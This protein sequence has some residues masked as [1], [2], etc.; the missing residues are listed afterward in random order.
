MYR[1]LLAAAAVIMLLA[2]AC[3]G[4]AD[5][6][7]AEPT[8]SPEV[9]GGC[10]P[11]RP[12]AAGETR[13]TMTSGAAERQYL[14]DVPPSYDGAAS[15][16]VVIAL[17]GLGSSAEQLRDMT[18]LDSA[19][20][21]RGMIVVFPQGAEIPAGWNIENFP[22]EPDDSTFI[23]DLIDALDE[24][25]C[26]DES[27]IYLSGYSNGGGMALRFACD[28]GGRVAGV[29]AVAATFPICQ[30]DAPLIAFHGNADLVVPYEGG[31]APGVTATLAPV[32]RAAS[33]WARLLGCDGL[34]RISRFAPDV[35]LATYANCPTASD[36]T[37]LYTVLGG[38]HTWP[39][40]VIDL[41][42]SLAG[43][44]TRSISA[45]EMMLDFFEAHGGQP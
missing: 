16:A 45:T 42:P 24:T 27:R 44:T 38:G 15:T 21:A 28:S 7:P 41:D 4:G 5:S 33:E 22:T 40:A 29:A 9:V 26:I 37:L 14:L 25:L 17:H 10:S 2:L 23:N 19:A 6:S 12:H 35:E 8:P 18:V 34:P 43:T 36:D 11:A 39:G 20:T 32:H 13:E 30:G 1:P 31:Q 3:D